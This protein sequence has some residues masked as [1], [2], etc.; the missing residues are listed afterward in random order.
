LLDPQELVLLADE[1]FLQLPYFWKYHL[2]TK[3][4][5]EISLGKLFEL[6]VM[7]E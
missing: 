4:S 7:L 1:R 6:N 3:L 5:D 2:V